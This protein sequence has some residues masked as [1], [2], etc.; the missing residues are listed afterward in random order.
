MVTLRNT[1]KEDL[2]YVLDA[3]NKASQ[4]AFVILWP[5]ER[6]L[7]AIENEFT[8]HQIIQADGKRVGYLIANRN[9]DDNYELMRIVVT[10]S[11]QGYGSQA[12]RLLMKFAFE[13]LDTNRFWLDV[14]MHNQNAISLY[15]TLGFKEEGI[16]RECVKHNDGYVSVMVMSVLRREYE[17]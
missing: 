15:K 13:E 3:E 10:K 11:G 5:E 12:I 8:D 6:H 2:E 9:P 7:K 14:R 1:N 17:I 16:L 4:N